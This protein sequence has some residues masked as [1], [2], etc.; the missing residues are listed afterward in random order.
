M[1]H[2]L[3]IA[4]SCACKIQVYSRWTLILLCLFSVTIGF[5]VLTVCVIL[6]IVVPL[7]ILL[8]QKSSRTGPKRRCCSR[9]PLEEI[10]QKLCEDEKGNFSVQNDEHVSA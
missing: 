4:I 9:T 2:H 3:R 6:L 10:T 7:L 5:I 1:I 8:M